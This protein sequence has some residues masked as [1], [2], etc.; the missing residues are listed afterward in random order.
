MKLRVGS[1]IVLAVLACLL[2]TSVAAAHDFWIEPSAFRAPAGVPVSL[3][4]RVGER[5]VGDPVPRD[6]TMIERFVAVGAS[7][8][9]RVVGRDG[10]DPAG[11]VALGS[12]GLWMVGYASRPTSIVIE[13]GKF[14]AYLASEGL[15]PISRLRAARGESAAPAHERFSRCAKSL[16]LAGEPPA[17]PAGIVTPLGFTF[18]IV[19]EGNPYEVRP[20]E[21]LAVRVLFDGAPYAGALVTALDQGRPDASGAIR[22]DRDG[23]A[24]VRLA[25]PGVWLVK[26]VHM[27]SLPPG[28]SDQYESY[29][30][31]LTFEVRP[32][33]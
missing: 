1:T 17:D 11:V 14:E 21:E 4:L 24:R 7:G 27:E 5:F 23:R 26:A 15:E 30:A 28:G 8:E 31:S 2:G 9:A 3:R 10:A 13:A 25:A 18:E 20:G 32:H 29:W 33:D 12:P 16:L 22:T 19:P 6:E